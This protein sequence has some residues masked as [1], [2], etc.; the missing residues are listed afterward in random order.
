[1]LLL[2]QHSP[3]ASMQ[4]QF[5][6]KKLDNMSASYKSLQ[7]RFFCIFAVLPPLCCMRAVHQPWQTSGMSL[8]FWKRIYDLLS[9]LI[10]SASQ[11]KMSDP[12]VSSQHGKFQELA[13]KAA[14]L[15]R[16]VD[17]YTE[18][19]ELESQLAEAKAM[20]KESAGELYN[21]LSTIPTPID[22]HTAGVGGVM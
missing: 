10:R 18:Y 6:L 13:K 5:V 17:G 20:L 16:A 11:E 22:A 19:R 8:F 15:Q 3:L 7:V 1:M 9:M 2:Q 14:E 4:D 21:I 12:D